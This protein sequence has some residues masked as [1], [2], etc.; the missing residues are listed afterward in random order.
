[1]GIQIKIDRDRDIRIQT[2]RD[3][4]PLSDS[5]PNIYRNTDRTTTPARA[6]TILRD[7]RR[8]K[9]ERVFGF[10]LD[11]FPLNATVAAVDCIQNFS[12]AA[13]SSADGAVSCLDVW[14]DVDGS[15]N[16]TTRARGFFAAS[17]SSK[18]LPGVASSATTFSAPTSRFRFADCA[19]VN[20]A[21]P[22]LD[23]AVFGNRGA[24]ERLNSRCRLSRDRGKS[25][26]VV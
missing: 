4:T 14:R 5:T 12:I 17:V 7:Q 13:M 24:D 22:P 19:R 6:V 8:H 16:A 21:T 11:G 26:G 9:P 15:A 25:R 10:E 2:D 20:H 3:R 18:G 23:D 1:M